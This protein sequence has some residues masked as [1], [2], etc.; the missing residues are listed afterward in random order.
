[1]S[2][3]KI[4]KYLKNLNQNQQIYGIMLINEFRKNN[5]FKDEKFSGD[6]I[7]CGSCI[8]NFSAKHLT[9]KAPIEIDVQVISK[10]NK[11]LQYKNK[12][13]KIVYSKSIT[14]E[15]IKEIVK[16]YV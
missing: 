6:G 15:I 1:M 8:I 14:P 3:F 2:N 12:V 13:L 16:L 9:I 5:K 4:D 11:K 7:T 10:I